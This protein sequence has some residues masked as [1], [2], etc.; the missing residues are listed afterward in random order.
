VIYTST[1]PFDDPALLLQLSW[2]PGVPNVKINLYHEGA[3]ADGTQ[4]LTLV[5]TTTTT[6]FDDWAQGFRRN[7]DGAIERDATGRAI[8][9]M[10]CP[11]Q[12]LDSPF[13]FTMENSTQALNPDEQIAANGRFKCYDGWS[14][15]DQV[16]PTPYNG[17]Y[18]FPSVVAK[19]S[20]AVGAPGS[21]PAATDS[22]TLELDPTTHKTNCTICT[23]GPDGTPMLPAGKY[24]VEIVLPPGYELVKEEDKNILLG[25]VYIAP[26]EQQ[27]AG[28][29]AIFI[30]PDQAMVNAQY[31]PYNTIQATANNNA[32]PR[33]EGD[34]G[35]VEVFWPCVG[36]Q[37]IVPDLN[38]L[39]PGAGQQAPFAGAT[40]PLCDRKEVTLTEQMTALAKFYV[41]TSAHIAGHYTGTITNDFA[42]EFDPFSPQFGEKFA[43]PNVPV[44][45]RDFSGKEIS[46]VYADQWGLF[47]G[48][49]YSTWTVN[50]PSPSGYIPQMMIACMNDPGPIPG[51]NG[52]MI[53]DPMYNPGY[54]NF[55]YEM[56]FM[57]GETAY[58]DT[59]VLPTMAFADGYNLPDCEYPDTTPAVA[60]VL[61][62]S[63]AGNG[64]GAGAGPWVSAA[65]Q[66]LTINALGDK[67]VLNHAYSGPNA[68]SAPFN[69]KYITRHYGFGA[70]PTNCPSSGDCLSATIA[71][72]PMR[73]VTTWDNTQ[74]VGLPPVL[75]A[76]QSTCTIAQRTSP[77]SLGTGARC[78][79]LVI[80]AANGNK[81]VDTITVTIGGKSPTY[82]TPSSPSNNL[83]DRL[84]ASPLQSAIDA[85]APGDLI[86]VGPGQYR[87][88]L[89]MWKPVRLQGVGAASVTLNAD[90]HP[91]GKIDA[92]RRQVNCLFGL[93]LDGRPSGTY[94]ANGRFFPAPYDGCQVDQL[95]KVDRNNRE[96][97]IGWDATTNGNLGQ[98]LQE[99]TLMGAYE[100]AG[101]SVVGKGVKYPRTEDPFAL[102]NAGAF[103]AGTV[104]LNNGGDCTNTGGG[105]N[106][107]TF[108]HATGNFLC[109]PSRID[110]ISVINSSQGG[111]AIF[112]HGWQH[113]MEVSNNRVYANHGTLTGGI[114]VGSGEFTVPYIAGG[115]DPIPFDV[116]NGTPDGTQLG[117]GM[118]TDVRVHH[119]SVTNN[120][121]IGDALYSG[122]NSAA[123]GVTFCTG[124][125]RYRFNDNWVCGNLS[126]GDGGGVV[127]SGFSND[128]TIAHN[129]IIFNQ[130]Q[131]PTI[132]TNGG[133]L[134]ILGASPDR[135][136]TQG[137][138]A[139]QECGTNNDLDC[140]PGLAEGTG[141]NLTVDANLIMGN[142][143]ESG[144]GGGI[145][146][147]LV[148]GEDVVAF[149]TRPNPITN[150]NV[151]NRSP[152]WNNVTI[153]N[154]IISNNVAGWDGAGVSMQDALKVTFINNTV[155]AND[156][157]ASAGVLF[158]TL[159][160]PM[161][162]VPPPGCTPQED[163]T[164]P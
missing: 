128:G 107:D 41:F 150:G 106:F 13:Y 164:Q 61:G 69:E 147:Q 65:G 118:N 54:S 5:D 153:T 14:M 152:G 154:N 73:N 119:N 36:Q 89:I 134:G 104:Y 158:N 112:L 90:A 117:Y 94:A 130:S 24:V 11:G 135:T 96:G 137:P 20:G 28:F 55:C 145:R 75:S 105:N 99:P 7:A 82:V 23:A 49:T 138:L 40:R 109:N 97:M 120:A 114:T 48:V 27:F 12:Q 43:V 66:S 121:S 146:L 6:S 50:P 46:R 47:N 16:Q 143:A 39:F 64:G 62:T 15:L 1:R 29:G 19:A 163:P 77:T 22:P 100:G 33:R 95:N 148:N 156:T 83:F 149:P 37:R 129:W 162:S 3:A 157:T 140:P 116:P 25:D 60:S 21:L 26:A 56:P 31:N 92:W 17:M 52:T 84:E 141:R 87:E 91:A 79:E 9:N 144:T 76:A 115:V 51:P 88:N 122:T 110:G 59:P 81:S 42:S 34:T 72:V 123:G 80:T 53:T 142:S 139:G 10:S 132:P 161:A 4:S 35:S 159:G 133:G 86:L 44:A 103:P 63:V 111:G 101:I 125:D 38:S 71:G 57:P 45:M 160:A 126:A 78:G 8:P 85:A 113:R 155:A 98:L 124:S 58:L 70:R 32:T 127:H 131:S 30:M 18:K 2:E 74:I 151:N 67:R 108:D 102:A 68:T 93:T 136:F